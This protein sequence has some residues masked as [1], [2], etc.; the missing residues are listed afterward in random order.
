MAAKDQ[1][2]GI[3]LPPGASSGGFDCVQCGRFVP[4]A[5]PGTANR[6]HCPHCLWSLHLDG[7]DGRRRSSCR[8]PMEPIAVWVKRNGEWAV[9]HRCTSCGAMT[10]NRVAGDDAELALMSLAVQP[11][12][13]PPFPLERLPRA[14]GALL[15]ASGGAPGVATQ[16]RPQAR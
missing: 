11:L 12:A 4:L 5:A 13:R 3:R 1:G 8:S 10:A 7:P 14:L 6:N 16:H 2:P 15:P 9:I